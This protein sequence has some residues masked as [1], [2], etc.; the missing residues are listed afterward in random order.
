[1]TTTIRSLTTRPRRLV[2]LC[3][4]AG[5]A[6]ALG[7]CG[8]DDDD[9]AEADAPAVCAPYIDVSISFNG[10]PDPAT[11]G[12]LLDQVDENAPEEIADSLAVMTGG[13]RDV[14]ETGDFTAFESP[15]FAEAQ[16][17]VDSWM[18]ENCEFDD[19][20]EVTAKDYSFE[21][22]PDTLDA[23]TAAILLTNDGAEPHEMAVMRK[24]E[25]VTQSW[26]EILALPQEEAEALVLQ[27]GGAFAPTNGAKGL[28]L[29]ELVPGDYVVACFV[30]TG[31]TMT[32]DGEFTEGTGA[33][34]FM[35]G[36]VKE[37]KVEA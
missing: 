17:E 2:A 12:P 5:L 16:S 32:A 20:A 36:M 37:F 14:L 28:A 35:A 29:L 34:H 18:F 23:G 15:E 13:A 10:E 11:L 8:D 1:M 6:L 26:E 21:G 30:P 9:D 31:T 24:A 27:V 19:T 33:P 3:A 7:A 25:G 4:S 22:L